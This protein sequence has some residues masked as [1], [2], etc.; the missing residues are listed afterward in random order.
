M[1]PENDYRKKFYRSYNSLYTEHMYGVVSLQRIEEQFY[2]WNA[3][4]SRF[5]PEKKDVKLLDLGC[6]EGGF[7]YWLRKKGFVEVK[8]IDVSSEQVKKAKELG[9]SGIMEGDVFS[10]LQEDQ[11]KFNTIFVRDFLEHLKKEEVIRFIELVGKKLETGGRIVIQTV[12][13]EAPMWGRIGYGDFTHETMFTERSIS[14]LLMVEGF[15]KISVYSQRPVIHGI[16]SFARM[17]LWRLFEVLMRL[18][19]LA[20]TGSSRGIFTQNLIASAQKRG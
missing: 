18:F 1:D 3:Y 16:V 12:N 7:V 6:G 2:I 4:F 20:G 8:G 15:E 10:F 11:E 9:I 14:Q 5:L 17:F 19:L 13:A